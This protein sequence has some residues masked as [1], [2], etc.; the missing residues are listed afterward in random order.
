MLEENTKGENNDTLRTGAPCAAPGPDD[1]LLWGPVLSTVGCLV[2]SLAFIPRENCCLR[3][4][5]SK[6]ERMA[7]EDLFQV[8]SSDWWEGS[9]SCRDQGS[10][11]PAKKGSWRAKPWG[12]SGEQIY[13][14][15]G[16]KGVGN[17][18]EKRQGPDSGRPGRLGSIH[19]QRGRHT[20]D[21]FKR[22]FK[23]H[24]A[25]NSCT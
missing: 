17:R 6:V 11:D 12:P 18:W 16:K 8:D 3:R 2:A 21:S 14:L 10:K 19:T 25:G 15:W 20:L 23:I 1:G 24:I 13:G 22:I 9:Q 5:G 7:R 4:R